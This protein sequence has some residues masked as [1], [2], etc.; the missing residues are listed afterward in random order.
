MLFLIVGKSAS[1][2][3]TLAK[4]MA[5]I[6]LTQVISRTDRP[7][8]TEEED[9]HIFVDE[10]TAK[11]ESGRAAAA[12][13]I[14]GHTYYALPEDIAKHDVYIVDPK[15]VR[16][17]CRNL[18][19]TTFHVVY[20]DADDGMRKTHAIARADDK[21]EAA[22]IFD[23]RN[24]SESPDFDEF[25]L[26]CTDQPDTLPKN[27]VCVT[28]IKNNYQPAYMAQTAENL[29]RYARRFYGVRDMIC[30]LS[31]YGV[32]DIDEN[33]QFKVMLGDQETRLPLEQVCAIYLADNSQLASLTRS[34]LGHKTPPSV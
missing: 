19:D 21:Q 28:V 9:T 33:S 8:R 32:F 5:E 27:I 29:A 25:R 34:W 4:A 12:T 3:D 2:K 10:E 30:D 14:A 6:G 11:S 24:A 20:I 1:G 15:G 23:E 31:R 16:D 17:L 7:R 26:L 18:P 13:T 22:R